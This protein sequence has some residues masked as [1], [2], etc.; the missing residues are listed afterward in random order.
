MKALTAEKLRTLLNYDPE[1]GVFSRAHGKPNVG[2]PYPNGYIG[3]RVDYQRYLAHRLA[4]L[5]VYGEWP[6]SEIDHIN[7]DK[8][9]NRICNLRLATRAENNANTRCRAKSGFKGVVLTKYGYRAAI[10]IN[11]RFKYLGLFKTPEEAHEAYCCAAREAFGDYHR[12]A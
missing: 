2:S 1:T 10:T 7:G 11:N 3:I 5:H 9:D 12:A 6:A 8:T 4:W